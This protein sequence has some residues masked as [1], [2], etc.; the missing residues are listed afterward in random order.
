VRIL[1]A[2]LLLAL[3]LAPLRAQESDDA[4]GSDNAAFV[5]SGI[6]VDFKAKTTDA[7][8]LA[9]YRAAQRQ[10][11]PQLWARLT[12]KDPASAPKL[13]DSALDAIVSGIEV[14]TERFSTTRYIARLGVVFDRVRA[15]KYAGS[16]GTV[17]TSQPMLL[18]PVL[19]DAGVRTVYETRSPWLAAW[20]RQRTGASPMQYVRASAI[21]GDAVL[22]N[23]WQAKRGDRR[24]WQNLMNRFRTADVLI[25]EAKL[26]RSYPG[27]PVIGT[28][29]ARHGPDARPLVRFRLRTGSARGLPGLLDEGVRR[30]DMAYAAAL[31]AGQLKSDPA[32]I[33]DLA[34]I[35]SGAPEIAVTVPLTGIDVSVQ[36]PDAASVTALQNSVRAAASVT[37]VGVTSLS[38]GGVS[39]VRIGYADSYQRLLYDLDQAGWRIVQT[40]QGPLLRRRQAGDA[41]VPPPAPPTSPMPTPATPQGESGTGPVDLLPGGNP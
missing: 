40:Q 33:A 20:S 18:M 30:I 12:A 25:A 39:R 17:L 14:E 1:S 31:R 32:L 4:G 23:A 26:E 8:R 13:G 16:S 24:L 15:G 7:A 21:A 9:A 38:L 35:E 5:V 11:W 36:T 2:L 29:T 41:P 34:P 37:G 19:D 3:A 6:E 27:G 10:A 22:L 28:F